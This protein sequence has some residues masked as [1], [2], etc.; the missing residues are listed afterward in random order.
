MVENEPIRFHVQGQ[1][2]HES[3]MALAKTGEAILKEF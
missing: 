1:P 3:M 2:L